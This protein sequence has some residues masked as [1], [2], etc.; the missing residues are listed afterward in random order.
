ML[1]PYFI[2]SEPALI[3]AVTVVARC[4]L[5]SPSLCQSVTPSASVPAMLITA[6]GVCVRVQTSYSASPLFTQL[7]TDQLRNMSVIT[8]QP[9]ASTLSEAQTRQAASLQSLPDVLLQSVMHSLSAVERL[10]FASCS[11][12]LLNV[13]FARLQ[14]EP[15]ALALFLAPSR[16]SARLLRC[17][18]VCAVWRDASF[19]GVSGD[20]LRSLR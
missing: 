10:T 20:T 3:S 9:V 4:A 6:H 17:V 16:T 13:A 12:P 19:D 11:Q 7:A 2:H 1:L 18:P 5:G 8:A 15:I 14:C